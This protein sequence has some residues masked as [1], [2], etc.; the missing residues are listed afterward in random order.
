MESYSNQECRGRQCLRA[1][2]S[3]LDQNIIKNS[4]SLCQSFEEIVLEKRIN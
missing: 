2:F 1:L 3:T 4:P